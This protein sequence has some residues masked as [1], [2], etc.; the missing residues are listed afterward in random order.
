MRIGIDARFYGPRVGGGG[1][2]RYVAELVTN[3][4]RIDTQNS[5]VLFLRKENFHECVITNPNF[6]K[7]LLDVPW[8]S[9]AEQRVLPREVALARFLVG[10]EA[11]DP[12]RGG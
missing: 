10:L 2:G 3:L 6:Q 12:S 9:L 5:Y 1:I 8:Y 4:Q 11:A 7:R